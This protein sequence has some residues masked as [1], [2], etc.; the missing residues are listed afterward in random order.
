MSIIWTANYSYPDIPLDENFDHAELGMS[1]RQNGHSHLAVDLFKLRFNPNLN[2]H[3]TNVERPDMVFLRAMLIRDDIYRNF[4]FLENSGVVFLNDIDAQYHASNKITIF[5]NLQKNNIPIPKT[6]Y[7]KIPFDETDI[8]QIDNEIGWPCVVKWMHGYARLGVELCES[9]DDLYRIIKNRKAI[10]NE[11]KISEFKFDGLIIQELIRTKH[12]VQIHGVGDV[13]HAV[14]QFTYKDYGFKSNLVKNAI[15]LPHKIDD[16]LRDI[17]SRVLR[18]LKL[19]SARIEVLLTSDGYKVCEVN[20]QGSH[21][22][23]TMTHLKNI[24]DILVSHLCKKY[25]KIKSTNGN[26]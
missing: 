5:K 15:T 22:W 20:P 16:E 10:A 18:S 11:H 1:I 8:D 17:S 6:I 21:G 24:S 13:Y 26:P 25:D 23:V 2:Y 9:P 7:I 4:K 3:G 19:D 12:V 14:M